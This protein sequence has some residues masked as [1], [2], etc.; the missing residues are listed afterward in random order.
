MMPAMALVAGPF[1]FGG[2]AVKVA[3]FVIALVACQAIFAIWAVQSGEPLY[4]SVGMCVWRAEAAG[5]AHRPKTGVPYRRLAHPLP[6]CRTE[7][8]PV[9]KMNV[10]SWFLMNMFISARRTARACT[11]RGTEAGTGKGAHGPASHPAPP[12][13]QTPQ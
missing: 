1:L 12:P 7:P 5:S 11:R 8:G 10:A 3:L 6:S 9:T 4:I 2:L 13:P